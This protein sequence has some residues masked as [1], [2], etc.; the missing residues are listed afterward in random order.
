MIKT[1]S[2][3]RVQESQLALDLVGLDHSFED[4]A[5]FQGL[6]IACEVVRHSKDSSE[7]VGRVAP[8]SS[9]PT[10]VEVEP[11]N[12]RANVERTP[13][14]VDLVVRARDLRA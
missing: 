1:D 10:V 2:V 6:T 3:E 11:A 5:N 7:V 13:D 14:G 8:L 4:I 9:K 12:L